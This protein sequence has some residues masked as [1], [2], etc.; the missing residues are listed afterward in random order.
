MKD[1]QVQ[2]RLICLATVAAMLFMLTGCGGGPAVYSITGKVTIG[3]KPAEGVR[4]SF[5][6]TDA[7]GIVATGVVNADGTYKVYSLLPEQQTASEGAL[8]GQYK[9][10][11][12]AGAGGGMQQ[13][14]FTTS[15]GSAPSVSG[16]AA[17]SQPYGAAGSG[18]TQPPGSGEPPFPKE[19]LS[20]ESSPKSFE[21]VAGANE[22]N[23]EL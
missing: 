1:I 15:E 22:C 9:V 2:K 3:G 16:G 21:V 11:L 20:A 12:A 18:P 13:P 8:P 7:A 17:G 23:L 4:I 6:P 19:Y 5:M 14:T 10:V